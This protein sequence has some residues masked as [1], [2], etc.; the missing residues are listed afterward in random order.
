MRVLA[1]TAPAVGHVLPM[2]PLLEA[3][4]ADGDDVTVACDESVRAHVDRTGA[5]FIQAGHAEPVWFERLAARTRGAP[6]DGLAAERIDHYFAPRAFGEIGGD[7]MVDDVLAAA[8][9]LEPDL[10]LHETYAIVGPLVAAACGC[11]RRTTTSGRSSP[12]TSSSS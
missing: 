1:V 6:G 3:M 2:A 10:V 4:V 12:R 5:S 9:Q 11:R 8:R 7:D